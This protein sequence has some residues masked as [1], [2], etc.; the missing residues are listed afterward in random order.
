[1]KGGGE[2]GGAYKNW[3]GFIHNFKQVFSLN[4]ES[5]EFM[6]SLNKT[7]SKVISRKKA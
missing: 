1:M 3:R 2:M 7:K 5:N 6:N 4:M